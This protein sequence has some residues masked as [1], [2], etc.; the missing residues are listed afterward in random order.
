MSTNLGSHTRGELMQPLLVA[1]AQRFNVMDEPLGLDDCEMSVAIE[2]HASGG[3]FFIYIAH[4]FTLHSKFSFFLSDAAVRIEIVSKALFVE[5]L[6]SLALLEVFQNVVLEGA[7]DNRALPV[8]GFCVLTQPQIEGA[9]SETN[10]K[11]LML[12]ALF[13]LVATARIG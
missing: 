11:G 5:L 9:G 12:Q 3:T 8:S 4:E 2:A 6:P 7:S 13:L 1:T 10:V